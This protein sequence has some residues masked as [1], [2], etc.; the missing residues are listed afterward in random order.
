MTFTKLKPSDQGFEEAQSKFL[1][2]YARMTSFGFPDPSTKE[3]LLWHLKEGWLDL[4]DLDPHEIQIAKEAG[5]IVTR[6]GVDI[7]LTNKK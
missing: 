6:D 3:G 1:Q 2:G 5:V 4:E 7:I